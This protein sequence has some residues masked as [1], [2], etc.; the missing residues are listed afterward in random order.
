VTE[1]LLFMYLPASHSDAIK[2]HGDI[3]VV[4]A[5]TSPIL[6]ARE[7]SPASDRNYE[8]RVSSSHVLF[9]VLREYLSYLGHFVLRTAL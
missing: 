9:R 8:I 1:F 5:R 2:R 3:E 6:I 7:K 4:R